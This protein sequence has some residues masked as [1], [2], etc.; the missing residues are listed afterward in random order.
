MKQKSIKKLK[1]RTQ[2]IE[3]LLTRSERKLIEAASKKYK[4]HLCNF[5]RH[6]SIDVAER[7]LNRRIAA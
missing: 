4:I 6:Y 5:M 3:V 1:E 7:I 2:R